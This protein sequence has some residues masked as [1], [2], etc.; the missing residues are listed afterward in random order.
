MKNISQDFYKK[1]AIE[2]IGHYQDDYNIF[3]NLLRILQNRKKLCEHAVQNKNLFEI[4]E[5]EKTL[6][7]NYDWHNEQIL[8][9]LNIII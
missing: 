9:V 5:Y 6:I 8:K 3:A 1:I 4:D 2:S 7:K